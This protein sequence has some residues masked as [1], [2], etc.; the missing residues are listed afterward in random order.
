[1][2]QESNKTQHRED[3]TGGASGVSLLSSG[4]EDDSFNPYKAKS[5]KSSMSSSLETKSV[6][7]SQA[8]FIS[9]TDSDARHLNLHLMQGNVD[10]SWIDPWEMTPSAKFYNKN[11][12]SPTRHLV[13]S[14]ILP[15]AV[16]NICSGNVQNNYSHSNISI[17]ISPTPMILNSATSSAIYSIDENENKSQKTN[18]PLESPLLLTRD[19]SVNIDI[20]NDQDTPSDASKF[21]PWDGVMT[22]ALLNIWGVILFLRLGILYIY[23]YMLDIL[24]NGLFF[25]LGF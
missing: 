7:Q 25:V 14:S 16:F 13:A 8:S 4:T 24:I 6:S 3:S 17:G 1:M 5:R 18:N 21:G 10:R 9:S 20:D 12:E 22:G 2:S 11:Y 15:N 19:D 23:I